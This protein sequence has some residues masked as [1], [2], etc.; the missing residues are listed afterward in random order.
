MASSKIVCLLCAC[1]ILHSVA[2]TLCLR[3][4]VCESCFRVNELTKIED[5]CSTC[6]EHKYAVGSRLERLCVRTPGYVC[7][8]NQYC[9]DIANLC[10]SHQYGAAMPSRGSPT[11]DC[12]TVVVFLTTLMTLI[13]K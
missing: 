3:C 11:K 4:F 12:R 5:G 6:V 10:N 1:V 8:E 7:A 13:F 2:M 9:C